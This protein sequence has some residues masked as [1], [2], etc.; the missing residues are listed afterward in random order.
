MQEGGIPKMLLSLPSWKQIVAC[1]LFLLRGSF[2]GP[3]GLFIA[4]SPRPNAL[5]DTE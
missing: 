5:F 2:E 4:L 3:S 1:D